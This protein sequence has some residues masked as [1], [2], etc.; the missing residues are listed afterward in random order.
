MKNEEQKSAFILRVEE[1]VKELETL[2]SDEGGGSEK[3]C[4][5]LVNEKP[6]D[7]DMTAQCVAIMGSGKGL[8]KSMSAFISNP[9]MAQV[10]EL[11]AKLAALEKIVKN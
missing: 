5:L 7:S 11:G 9:E 8:V 1:M 2:V 3:S 10:V 4:I 6:Q